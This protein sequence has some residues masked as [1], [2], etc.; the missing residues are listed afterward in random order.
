MSVS[1]VIS[2]YASIRDIHLTAQ[3]V[4]LSSWKKSATKLYPLIFL[5]LNFKLESL[6]LKKKRDT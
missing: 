1:D 5:M 3:T 4:S 2:Y 6:Y